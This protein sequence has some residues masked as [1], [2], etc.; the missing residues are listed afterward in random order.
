M[1][2]A[3]LCV[4]VCVCVYVCV[5]LVREVGLEREAEGRER[6]P[7]EVVEVWCVFLVALVSVANTD[8]RVQ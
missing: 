4:C 6:A 7:R 8:W 3:L 2:D 5:G 1:Q